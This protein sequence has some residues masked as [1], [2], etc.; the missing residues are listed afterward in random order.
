[1]YSKS[2]LVKGKS[3]IVKKVAKGLKVPV[4]ELG[5]HGCNKS[6][7]MLMKKVG[8][9]VVIEQSNERS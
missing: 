8:F 4:R 1:M 5:L 9:R 6:D 7:L 2:P 3:H